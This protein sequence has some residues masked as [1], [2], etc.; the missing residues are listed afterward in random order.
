[1]FFDNIVPKENNALV[2]S[3]S[4][5][6]SLHCSHFQLSALSGNINLGQ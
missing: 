3:G 1:M 5:W 2:A 6:Y 4:D